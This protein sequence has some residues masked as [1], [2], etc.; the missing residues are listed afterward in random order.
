MLKWFSAGLVVILLIAGLAWMNW[1]NSPMREMERSSAVV[2]SAKSWHYH[3]M[4]TPPGL[5]PDTFDKDTFCPT[6]QRTIQ[7]GTDRNG[8][9]VVFDTIIYFG[10]SYSHVGD[11]WTASTGRQADINAQGSL[12][13]FECPNRALGSDEN[14]LPYES[15]LKDGTVQRGGV[16]EVEG[17]SCRDYEVAVATPHDPQEKEFKFSICISEQDHLPRQTRRTAPGSDQESVSTYTQWNAV[18][19]PQLPAGFPR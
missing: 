17:D 5:P 8:A 2:E 13:I 10:R 19:E 11:Q 12:P 7:S 6:F 9:P 4:R 16:R 1:R 3:S 15:I 18:T 14:S